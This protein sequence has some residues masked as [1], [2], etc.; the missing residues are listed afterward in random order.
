MRPPRLHPRLQFNLDSTYLLKYQSV[1]NA[2]SNKSLDNRDVEFAYYRR[3]MGHRGR[4]TYDLITFDEI[5]N[6]VREHVFEL[7]ITS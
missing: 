7:A 1:E 6:G 5:K 4:T 3:A 2:E